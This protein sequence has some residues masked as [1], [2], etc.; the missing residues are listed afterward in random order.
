MRVVNRFGRK[1]VD[2]KVYFITLASA[3]VLIRKI[4]EG[5]TAY[6]RE[7]GQNILWQLLTGNKNKILLQ[8]TTSWMKPP[9]ETTKLT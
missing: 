5:Q 6:V 8:R 1:K 2:L 3:S 7:E 4:V 9:E